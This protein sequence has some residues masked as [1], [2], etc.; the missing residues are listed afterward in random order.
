M[1]S[2]A[3]PAS[4]EVLP[5]TSPSGSRAL[6][7][8]DL[9]REVQQEIV[10]HCDIPELVCLS[11]VSKH[12]HVLAAAVLYRHFHLVFP[13]EDNLQFDNSV[14]YLARGLDTF[15][16][17]DYNY[18]QYLRDV[19]FDTYYLGDKAEGSYRPYLAS[20]SCGKFLNT[21]LL[22]T[23]RKARGLEAFK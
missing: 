8:V 15:V 16:T 19:A 21:L 4:P 2:V 7:L 11:V 14:D 12:F 6:N 3:S 22:L 23:L 20:L 9:P 1:A 10:E 18:A 13:D 5:A 17:S